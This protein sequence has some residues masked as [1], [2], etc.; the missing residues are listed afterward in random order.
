M[1]YLRRYRVALAERRMREEKISI[2]QAARA[3]GYRSAGAFRRAAR[4]C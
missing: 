1:R 2:K 3:C 4:R